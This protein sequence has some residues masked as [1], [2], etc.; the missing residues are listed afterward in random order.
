[1]P[2]RDLYMH[3]HNTFICNSKRPPS[4]DDEINTWWDVQSTPRIHFPNNF[5]CDKS[6]AQ[7]P[8]CSMIPFIW[9]S[10]WG[11]SLVTMQVSDCPGLGW[12]K[13][14]DFKGSTR[15]LFGRWNPASYW[16]KPPSNAKAKKNFWEVWVVKETW[17]GDGRWQNQTKI[18]SQLCPG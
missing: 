18:I 9:N 6:Q 5:L 10:R 13:W 16:N 12:Q 4:N 11:K 7:K 15:E 8:M 3:V 1:M 14:T 17:T 2:L